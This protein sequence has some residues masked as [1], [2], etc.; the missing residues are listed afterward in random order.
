MLSDFCLNNAHQTSEKN[1]KPKT[2]MPKCEKSRRKAKGQAC[3]EASFLYKPQYNI[4]CNKMFA[5]EIIFQ[6]IIIVD[7][8]YLANEFDVAEING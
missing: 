2:C 1:R 8:R 3:T 6:K 5:I 4:H 7:S